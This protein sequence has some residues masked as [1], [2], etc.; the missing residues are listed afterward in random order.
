MQSQ[1]RRVRIAGTGSFVPDGRLLSTE[2]DRDIGRRPGFI[3]SLT[4]VESRPVAS[5]ID[6]IGMAVA[7][8]RLALQAAAASPDQ[9]DLVLF[10]AAVPYQSI[11]ATAP[12]VQRELGVPS[13][14]AAA[15]DINA[16]C[17]SFL[18]ATDLA[19]SLLASGQYR[20]ALVVSSEIASRALPWKNAPLTAAL[21]GDGAGAAVLEPCAP[22]DGACIAASLMETYPE[23]FDACRLGA[24]GTRYDYH[25]DPDGFAANS[26]FEMDGKALYRLTFS[27]FEGFLDRLLERA[28]WNRS[29]VDIVLPHQAS[30]SALNHL[31]ERCGFAP[32]KVVNIIATHGN[33][34]A[35]SLASVL[36]LA[37]RNQSLKPGTKALM[38]GTSAGLSLGGL[39]FVA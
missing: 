33:Q 35:A 18:A 7:A 28:G 10:G 14:R 36:D 30:A 4:S 5:E 26:L 27:V 25:R 32:S 37:M 19:A 12:L 17:L 23:G 9:I 20:K 29:D 6:Q 2:I 24:G 3:E 15:F 34:I 13:G 8:S 21:F 16:T 22:D 38:I 31:V 11:P 1:I 39:A